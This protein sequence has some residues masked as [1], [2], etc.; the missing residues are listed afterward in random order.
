[1]LNKIQKLGCKKP[2]KQQVKTSHGGELFPKCGF[3]LA[4]TN[5]IILEQMTE[6]AQNQ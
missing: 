5:E 3:F 6:I 1:M 4:G 2:P